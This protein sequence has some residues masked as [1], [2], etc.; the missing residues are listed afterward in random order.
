MR[1]HQLL[2][3]SHRCPVWLRALFTLL[4]G[5]LLLAA[6]NVHAQGTS[7][8]TITYIHTDIGGSPLAATDA[9]GTVVWKESYRGYGQRWLYQGSSASQPQWF[10]GK[11]QDAATGWQYFGARYYDPAVGRFMGIDPVDFQD[12]NLHSFNRYA[13]GNNNP[14]RYLDPDGGYAEV[15][16]EAL[17]LAVGIDSLRQNIGAGKYGAAAVDGVG[18]ALDAVLTA[19]P[20]APGAVGLGIKAFRQSGEV[21]AKEGKTLFHYTDAAG[22]KGIA[23]SGVIR[24]DVK[25]RVFVT[26]QRLSSAEVKN[27]LFIGR[28][29]DKGS[30]VVEIQAAPSLSIRQGKNANELIHQGSIRDGRQGTLTVKPNE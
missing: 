27:R 15:A 12:G 3:K 17:S 6:G 29:G 19:I 9:N 21:A 4:L 5:A 22:A 14:I 30:H 26:D 11:E 18:V 10:H 13:Y 25:G 23:E 28:S 16:L 20:G 1:T 24:A 8:E 2:L 7:G